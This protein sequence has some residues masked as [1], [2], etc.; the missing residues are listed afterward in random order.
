MGAS[1]SRLRV[2][3]GVLASVL[4]PGTVPLGGKAQQAPWAG[5]CGASFRALVLRAGA[6]PPGDPVGKPANPE[7]VSF[8]KRRARGG[9]GTQGQPGSSCRGRIS[10]FLACVALVLWSFAHPALGGEVEPCSGFSGWAALVCI[11]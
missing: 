7:C 9:V 10:W 11:S 6:E 3:C 2:P 5:V 4:E 1:V 8:W